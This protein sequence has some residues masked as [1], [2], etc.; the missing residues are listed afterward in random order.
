MQ[1]SGTRNIF[2]WWAGLQTTEMGGGNFQKR[3]GVSLKS[4][5]YII[6]LQGVAQRDGAGIS[7]NTMGSIFQEAWKHIFPILIM[8]QNIIFREINWLLGLDSE[9]GWFKYWLSYFRCMQ[10]KAYIGYTWRSHLNWKVVR[11]AIIAYWLLHLEKHKSQFWLVL[12]YYEERNIFNWPER[13]YLVEMARC[14]HKSHLIK[15]RYSATSDN[16]PVSSVWWSLFPLLNLPRKAS[17]MTIVQKVTV[18]LIHFVRMQSDQRQPFVGT[19]L[20]G[21]GNCL[22][23][24]YCK[25]PSTDNVKVGELSSIFLP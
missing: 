11:R 1:V 19:Q 3:P 7:S 18:I 20:H 15:S 14:H 12:P 16:V 8:T 22:I 2:S 17:V 5:R 10:K 24:Q 23:N 25:A 9:K 4:V 21:A 13:S 6:L